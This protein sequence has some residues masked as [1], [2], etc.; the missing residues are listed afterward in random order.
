[1]DVIS[2]SK[3]VRI[4]PQKARDLIRE[5]RGKTAK[6]AVMLTQFG[7]RKAAKEI[8]KTLKSAI[9]N[10]EA[11]HSLSIDQ[12]SVK[13]A[14]VDEGARMRRF[15][16]RPRGGVSPIARRTC[17]ITIVLTDGKI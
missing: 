17:H 2:K 3:H 11:N 13:K 16:P 1:M 7:Y 15:W 5:I 6:S 4:P 8:G 14:V 10:A 12:L 9:A